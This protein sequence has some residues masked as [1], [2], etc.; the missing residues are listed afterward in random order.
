MQ[1][2][3]EPTGKGIRESGLGDRRGVALVIV[4]GLL[5]LMVVMGVSFS[6]FMRTERVAA[7]SFRNDVRTRQ[8]LHAALNRALADIDTSTTNANYPAWLYRESGSAAGGTLIAGVTNA[9]AMDWIPRGALGPNPNPQP[10][11]IDPVDP[12]GK[13]DAR[14]GF[15]VV[16]C[17]GLVDA[18]QHYGPPRGLGVDTSEIQANVLPDVKN[19]GTLFA[20]APYASMQELTCVGTNK[21]A[22]NS[23]PINLV[24]YSACPSGRWDIATSRVMTDMVDIGGDG[25]DPQIKANL[26]NCLQVTDADADFIVKN[27]QD[28]IDADCV[29]K[30]LV[31]PCTESVPMIN[32]VQV[33]TQFVTVDANGNDLPPG[34]CAPFVTVSVEWFYPFVKASANTFEI[35]PFITLKEN[36]PAFAVTP[37]PQD[38]IDAGYTPGQA[39]GAPPHYVTK[40]TMGGVISNGT[41]NMSFDVTA[42][43]Q[44]LQGGNVVD[45]VQTPFTFTTKALAVGK[46]DVTT[47]GAECIDPRFNW[48]GTTGDSGAGQWMAYGDIAAGYAGSLEQMNTYTLQYIADPRNVTDHHTQM[49]VADR[50]LK[51]VGELSYL[52]RGKDIGNLWRTI[53]LYDNGSDA[54]MDPVLDY[55]TIGTA[56]KGRINPNTRQTDVVAALMTDLPLDNYPEEPGA[57]TV[58]G[59][60]LSDTTNWWVNAGA[61]SGTITNL[62][63]I[64]HLTGL[65]TLPSTTNLTFFQKEALIRNSA[66]LMAPRQ[67][68]FVILL[69]AQTTKVVPQVTD[70][71]VVAGTRGIAEVWRDAYP[72][73]SG[74]HPCVIRLFKL[75]NEK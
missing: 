15:L 65:F 18:N 63:D 27:L 75:V 35:K 16:N 62:S 22:L 20:N 70:K 7:G 73:A 9:P 48:D 46:T 58:S 5:A 60:T 3:C 39:P 1:R 53:G 43:F 8:L 32:E 64:G 50:P 52:L 6:I 28:Y 23:S 19:V 42:R 11:W 44:V 37:I 25:T 29:P 49:F 61:V 31:S 67:Q 24:D 14:V 55:F 2:S 54:P 45:D 34:C 59:T 33:Q 69:F 40:T 12:T 38:L 68:Y 51:V 72:N 56:P 57:P 17:S 41:G 10:K 26:K 74:R 13:L 30:D 47:D 66:G 71:S 4:L 36:L 21:G